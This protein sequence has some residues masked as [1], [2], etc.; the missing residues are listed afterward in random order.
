L[1]II[2]SARRVDVINGWRFLIKLQPHTFYSLYKSIRKRVEG[3]LACTGNMRKCLA[4]KSEENKE[5][6]ES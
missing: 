3:N 4:P 6:G 1:N 5:T 2:F